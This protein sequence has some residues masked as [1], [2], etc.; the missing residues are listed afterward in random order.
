MHMGC[1]PT[2]TKPPR[3]GPSKPPCSGAPLA[4]VS[5]QRGARVADAT[6]A[7]PRAQYGPLGFGQNWAPHWGERHPPPHKP[8]AS[9]LSLGPET[10]SQT[11][12][13][14]QKHKSHLHPTAHSPQS[15]PHRKGHGGAGEPT[16]ACFTHPMPGSGCSPEAARQ[17]PAPQP[18]FLGQPAGLPGCPPPGRD[19]SWGAL[20]NMAKLKR[21][22]MTLI[23][24]KH[25]I[26]APGESREVIRGTPP[27][28]HD[29]C[30]PASGA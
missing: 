5:A 19:I 14:S 11:P 1:S 2:E 21:I 9:V 18:S 17:T 25:P 20:T 10:K 4:R 24:V 16:R 13:G 30:P 27:P 28:R 3:Q 12:V 29:P 23:K 26:F 22:I 7:A 8:R 15:L 6:A